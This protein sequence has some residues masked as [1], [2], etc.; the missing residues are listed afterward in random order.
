V[1]WAKQT[2]L[3]IVTS[4][5]PDTEEAITTEMKVYPITMTANGSNV[6]F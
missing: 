1:L 5:D 2:T 6:D 3:D 4:Y